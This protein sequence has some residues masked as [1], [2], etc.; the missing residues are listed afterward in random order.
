[1]VLKP[2]SR[3]KIQIPS[4]DAIVSESMLSIYNQ[5]LYLSLKFVDRNWVPQDPTDRIMVQFQVWSCKGSGC[6]TKENDPKWY[7]AYV[8]RDMLDPNGWAGIEV[9]T[10]PGLKY[11]VYYK[12]SRPASPY[13]ST[14]AV[15]GNSDSWFFNSFVEP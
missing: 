1:M 6:F 2:V 11:R 4:H 14:D 5:K 9:A 8:T 13:Y 7:T 15:D 10:Y 3:H 12:L